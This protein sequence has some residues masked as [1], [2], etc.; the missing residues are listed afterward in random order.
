MFSLVNRFRPFCGRMTLHVSGVVAVG[1][2]WSTT[3]AICAPI[4]RQP[5][6]LWFSSK[7]GSREDCPLCQKFGTGPCGELFYKWLDC[8]DEDP[9]YATS[10]CASQFDRF[11]ECLE[12]EEKYYAK[13]LVNDDIDDDSENTDGSIRSAWEDL[14]REDLEGVKRQDF[15][16]PM[17]PQIVPAGERLR[18]T[19]VAESLVLVFVHQMDE[20]VSAGSKADLIPT[21]DG[22]KLSLEFLL[23]IDD[24]D[25]VRISAVYELPE[26][27][28]VVVYEQQIRRG[29][30]F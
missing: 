1:S 25:G 24:G 9:E 26:S 6:A 4:R 22:C 21:D 7:T 8:T 10:R 19:F 17:L 18:L 12:R 2:A 29:D 14:I 15:P 23:S 30:Y 11:Q 16:A 28:D 20:L 27:Q 5:P 13:D 3:V